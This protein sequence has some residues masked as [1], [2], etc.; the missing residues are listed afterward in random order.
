MKKITIFAVVIF[1]LM[2]SAPVANAA[3]PTKDSMMTM[4]ELSGSL[5]ILHPMMQQISAMTMDDIKSKAPNLSDKAHEVITEELDLSIDLMLAEIISLQIDYLSKYLTQS[6][7]DQ[8]IDIY[9]SPVWKKNIAIN[10]QYM[11]DEYRKLMQVNLPRMTD[12][13][14]ERILSRLEKENLLSNEKSGA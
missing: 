13:M 7:V 14:M 2:L 12:E 3:K 1:T 11:Q 10:Q 9:S 4:L 6:D 5:Q 8:L